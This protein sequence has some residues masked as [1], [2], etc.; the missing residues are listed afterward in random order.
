MPTAPLNLRNFS[1]DFKAAVALEALRGLVLKSGITS[2]VCSSL[3]R[4]RL[5]GNPHC[6]KSVAHSDFWLIR[7]PFGEQKWYEWMKHIQGTSR[8]QTLLLPAYVDDYVGPDNVVRFIEAFV[9]C[10]DLAAAG[11]DKGSMGS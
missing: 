6:V 4:P 3:K 8:S 10:L 1:D 7:I 5:R 2:L 11:F 9:D